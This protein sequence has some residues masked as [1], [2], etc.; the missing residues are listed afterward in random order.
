MSEDFHSNLLIQVQE[1]ERTLQMKRMKLERIQNEKKMMKIDLKF[2]S[3]VIESTRRQL[4]EREMQIKEETLRMEASELK[5]VET[6]NKRNKIENDLEIHQQQIERMETMNKQQIETFNDLFTNIGKQNMEIMMNKFKKAQQ[7]LFDLHS[8]QNVDRK[9]PE[10]IEIDDE[11]EGEQSAID[12]E[13][14]QTLYVSLKE[15]LDQNHQIKK[16]LNEKHNKLT[17]ELK[18]LSKTIDKMTQFASEI[19]DK[20]SEKPAAKEKKKTVV[21]KAIWSLFLQRYRAVQEYLRSVCRFNELAVIPA[22]EA[23]KITNKQ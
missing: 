19:Q 21:E 22:M 2:K 9:A 1:K 18:E 23:M 20:L 8:Q 16:E 12:K 6:R 11:D 5:L 7:L 4:K 14:I 13:E 10:V 3:N 17:A 15:S